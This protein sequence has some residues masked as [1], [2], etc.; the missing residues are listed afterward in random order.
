MTDSGLE[1]LKEATEAQHGGTATFCHS[2]RVREMYRHEDVWDVV[3]HVFFLP[4]HPKAC[5]AYVWL[6]PIDN[7]RVYAL[8]HM[9]A[10]IGPVEAVHAALMAA[11]REREQEPGGN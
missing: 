9:G 6:S 5:W 8:L 2:V 7:R 11:N 1:A 4:D 3:V 10:I